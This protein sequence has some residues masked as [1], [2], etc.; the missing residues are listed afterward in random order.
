MNKP[1]RPGP[2]AG[3]DKPDARRW[4]ALAV[5]SSALLLIVI[6][7]TVLYTAL[8]ILTHDLRASAAQKLWIVNMYPLVVAGLLPGTGTLGD[9]LGHRRVFAAG[10]ALFGL[11]SVWAA[12]SPSAASLIAA[13]AALACGAALMMPATLALIRLTFVDERERGLAIGIWASVA[14]G[15]AALGPVLGGFLLT[16]FWWGSVFL[17]NV[18]AV[19]LSLGLVFAVISPDRQRQGAG[20]ARAVWDWPSSLLALLGMLGLTY[21]I[22]AAAQL[23]PPWA[24]VALAAAVG[25]ALLVLFVRRQQRIAH[26]LIDFSLLRLPGLGSGVAAAL[27]CSIAF[28]GFQLVFSQWLQLVRALSPLQAGLYAL[29]IALASFLAGPLAGALAGRGGPR[30]VILGGM[31]VCMAGLLGTLALYQGMGWP[32]V[33]ALAL[34]GGGYGVAVTGASSAVML[35]A[36]EDKAGMAAS[37]EEVS[38]ELG[39][40]L[41]VAL[42]GSLMTAVYAASLHLPDASAYA[43]LPQ[44]YDSLDEARLAAETLPAP[45]ADAL[46]QA[47]SAAFE[48][49]FVAVASASAALLA[50]TLL[51]L[52]LWRPA[53]PAQ[54][55][56]A[57]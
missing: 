29:P 34:L 46:R 53:R 23:R 21:A 40:L 42:L 17:I 25:L 2:A 32:L 18:P 50:A 47:A 12:Y 8:P 6:D 35:G 44:I 10:L 28:I 7:M 55:P 38:Y 33:A 24:Q 27:M 31:A 19:L 41:G 11:A 13:R 5:L 37:M 43:A 39:G 49:A 1:L 4:L 9:R 51:A 14:S 36:P 45:W 48:R 15:G 3:P 52:W 30:A 20:Q 22:Q 54:R 16:R 56:L 26:P 57:E